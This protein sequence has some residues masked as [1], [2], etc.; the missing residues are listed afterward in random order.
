MTLVRFNRENENMPVFSKMFENFFNDDFM[1]RRF[2][3]QTP[4]VNVV[5]EDDQFVI[6][7]AAP[8]LTKKDFKVNLDNDFITIEA[9][10]ESKDKK[11]EKNYTRREFC[12]ENFSRTFSIPDSVN[13]EKIDATYNEGVLTVKLPKREEAKVKPAREIKIA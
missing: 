4:A 3:S 1:P 10:K 9:N 5:E 11:E 6:E 7:V 13:S 8:G 2:T 12:Y